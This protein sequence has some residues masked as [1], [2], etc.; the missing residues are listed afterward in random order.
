MEYLTKL[1]KLKF[2]DKDIYFNISLSIIFK[3][4]TVLGNLLLIP[5]T[6][7][8]LNKET[9]GIWVT[10]ST[11]LISLTLFD[12]GITNGLRNRLVQTFENRN[13]DLSKKYISTAYT[14]V[15]L[16][17]LFLSG[18]YLIFISIFDLQQFLFSDSIE[19][20]INLTLHISFYLFLFRFVL[21][22]INAINLAKQKSGLN[23]L[24]HFLSILFTLLILYFTKSVFSLSLLEVVIIYCAV[25]I[26]VYFFYSNYF[27]SRNKDLIPSF[28]SFD[29]KLV[30]SVLGISLAFLFCQLGY[31]FL[32]S[33]PILLIGKIYNT[34]LVTEYNI[35]SKLYGVIY[36][37]LSII[38]T[39]YWSAFTKAKIT[40]ESEWIKSN[41]KKVQ[42]IS[43]G[44]I[45]LLIIVHAF[46]NQIFSFWL[47]DKVTISTE[48][49]L[50]VLF[51][52]IV[53]VFITPINFFLNG[54]GK[55]QIQVY[56]TIT[57][58]VLYPLICYFLFYFT[59]LEATSFVYSASLLMFFNYLVS[60]LVIYKNHYYLNK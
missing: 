25:P 28:Y 13:G 3:G 16:I 50:S 37:G 30:K 31:I 55:L 5:L 44:F 34:S 59:S 57:N 40:G 10:I 23:D 12:L 32:T 20:N 51:F 43:Y 26:V 33:L 53:L 46:S 22:T 6:I 41:L 14:L 42:F 4:L 45:F 19:E 47:K 9:F 18:F 39:P 11:I 24:I 7:D 60:K 38:L 1:L 52:Q 29:K 56:L 21:M 58:F 2:I 35:S 49:D 36:M 8:I 27:F 54:M 17:A 48:M 15:S